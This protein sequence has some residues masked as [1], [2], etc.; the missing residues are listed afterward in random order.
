MKSKSAKVSS[1]VAASNH[2][3][4]G[5]PDAASV[6]AV[7]M[8]FKPMDGNARLALL[9]I[10]ADQRAETENALVE[11]CHKHSELAADLGTLAPDS[12]VT[13]GL[14][15]RMLTARELNKKA[16]ALAVYAD[17][18]EAVA[19]H[20]VMGHLN[21]VVA[22][23][24]HMAS[25]KPGILEHYEK[26]LAVMAQR[27]EAISAGIARSKATSNGGVAPTQKTEDGAPA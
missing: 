10:Y 19:N 12:G 18:L 25:R 3:V 6:P 9:K 21:E 20:A 14:L 17:E 4:E 13:K 26:V 11:I 24:E 15:E 16:Q 27:R 23:I 8:A 2:H 22:D 7:P 5:A 1:A